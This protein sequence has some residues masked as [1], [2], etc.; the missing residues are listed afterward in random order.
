MRGEFELIDRLCRGLGASRRTILGPGDDCAIV[1]RSRWPSVITVDSMV[2]GRHFKIGWGAP[3]QIG[4]RAMLVNL[5]DI[6]AMGAR[7][8]HCV[9]NL[10][11][12]RGLSTSFIERL[13]DGLKR[14]ARDASMD[15]V[16]GNVTGADNLAITVTVVGELR[17]PALRRDQARVND[18]IF[19]TGT[20]GDAALGWRIL[21][22]TLTVANHRSRSWLVSRCLQPSPRISAGQ[23][24]A[25]LKPTPAAIDVSDGLAQD[26]GHILERSKLGAEVEVDSIPLSPAY[27][28]IAG[29]DRA[30]ALTGGE[31]YELIFTIRPGFDEAALSKRLGVSVGRIGRIVARRGLRILREGKPARRA[32]AR[33]RGWDQLRDH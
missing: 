4:A 3:E 1:A 32:Q 10:A 16:G 6:A 14:T 23:V 33:L 11:V 17:G 7:P 31:D 5:S 19:V 9:V 26:L 27:R 25:R 30:L 21:E 15:L 12:R 20:F 8:S 2:E 13:Y 22:G 24:L 18:E 28:S 29:D